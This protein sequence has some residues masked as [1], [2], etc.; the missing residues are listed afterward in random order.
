MAV[1]KN[2]WRKI[3]VITQ[4][5][6]YRGKTAQQLRF[7]LDYDHLMTPFETPLGRGESLRQRAA[8]A[9]GV[10]RLA[11]ERALMLPQPFS[12]KHGEPNVVLRG[13]IVTEL[14]AFA[15]VEAG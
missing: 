6:F 5:A 2:G 9:P 7:T 3:V 4:A 12:G 8:V 10:V 11:I 15:R 13:K 14:Q 1:P